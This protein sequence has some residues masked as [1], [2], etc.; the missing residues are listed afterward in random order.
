[1]V[2][3][4]VLFVVVKI[5]V[6]KM[7]VV[8]ILVNQRR[9]GLYACVHRVTKHEMIRIIKNVKILMNV[10]LKGHVN[11][12]VLTFVAATIVHVHLDISSLEEKYVK[13]GLENMQK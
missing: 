11:K 5:V 8:R 1:M 2:Q 3:T 12:C 6:S 13:L 7:E 4:R 9:P 10:Q